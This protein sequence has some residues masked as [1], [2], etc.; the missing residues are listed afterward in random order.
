MSNITGLTYKCNV[1]DMMS[2]L[3][4][5]RASRAL[6]VLGVVVAGAACQPAPGH[7]GTLSPT[8]TLPSGATCASQVRSAPETRS[9]NNT[10]N[11]TRGTQKNL[12]QPYPEFARVDGNFVGTTDEI[13]QWASCKWGLDEDIV[14]AQVAKESWWYQRTV[15]D[16]QSDSSKCVPGHGIGADGHPG[17]CPAS[18][19]LLALTYQY[20]PQGFPQAMNS[21]AYNLDYSL[22]WWRACYTG[23]ITWLNEVEHGSTYGAGDA[24]G[25][26]GEW[27]SGRWHTPAAE[28]YITAVKQYKDQK[29]WTSAGFLS[30]T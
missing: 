23:K 25:C 21:S 3:V 20:W 18:G 19:G 12:T 26:V 30:T 14:R 15:G 17:Q 13:I 29:V 16:F 8:A 10:A 28:G 24:W 2:S 22:A 6:L 7:F 27:F 4:R 5:S 11:H 1:T 9:A